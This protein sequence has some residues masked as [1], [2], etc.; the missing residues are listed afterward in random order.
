M[1]NVLA[2]GGRTMMRAAADAAQRSSHA[3]AGTRP[4]VIAVTV[5]TSMDQSLL[6][7]T[8]VDRPILDQVVLLAR[9]AQDAGL[10]GVVASPHE[11]GAIRDACGR[12][13]LIVTPGIRP[14][15]SAVQQDDQRRTMTPAE[16]VRT[17]ASYL[18]IGRPI[19][20]AGDPATAAAAITDS[21][22]SAVA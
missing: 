21:I 7:E 15:S 10:D 3:S 14:A 4:L 17:G 8:G 9:L 13:F 20:G 1:I 2:S 19:T 11:I 6:R 12:E 5:L 16:A 18:V 22:E